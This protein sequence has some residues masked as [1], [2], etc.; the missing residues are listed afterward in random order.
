MSTPPSRIW[1][2]IHWPQLADG[3]AADWIAVLPLA[4]T[5]QHGPHLPLATDIVIARAYLSAVQAMLPAHVPAVFLPLEE[6]G[7]SIEHTGYPGTLTLSPAVAMDGW[8]AIGESVARAGVRKLV[9]VTSHGGNSAAMDLVALDLR[10]RLGMLVVTTGW[11]RFGQPDGLLPADEIR[12]GIHGG[13]IETSIMLAA[14]PDTVRTDRIADF[15]PASLAMAREFRWL[16]TLRPA[17]FAWMMQDLNRHGAAGNATL[18]SAEKGRALIAHGAQGFCELL[19]EV[20]AFDLARLGP[21]VPL[22]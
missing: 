5:E 21:P 13:A 9:M 18:A 10:A 11:H 15:V 22:C 16:N 1:S 14:D 6:I 2:D 17:P 12:H 20:N 4:A 19:Q 8:R 3:A 7:I